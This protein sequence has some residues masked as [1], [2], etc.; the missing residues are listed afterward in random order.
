[1]TTAYSIA[2]TIL[3]A[4]HW[5]WA[6]LDKPGQRR[7]KRDIHL[8]GIASLLQV[9][10]DLAHMLY[11]TRRRMLT[12]V[13]SNSSLKYLH[14]KSKQIPSQG[15]V[16]IRMISKLH[17]QIYDNMSYQRPFELSSLMKA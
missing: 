10:L 12:Q 2:W 9:H 7:C 13:T 8:V 17:G 6:A 1:M 11:G 5:M 14:H 3:N 15:S 16:P 4:S